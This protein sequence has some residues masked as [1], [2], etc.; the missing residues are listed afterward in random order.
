M[1]NRLLFIGLW[2]LLLSRAG[3]LSGAPLPGPP[4][5]YDIRDYGA[6]PSRTGNAQA[7]IQRAIEACAAAG[8][9]QVL[10]PAGVF[11]TATIYLRNNVELR[12]ASGATLLA[13]SDS[14]LYRNDKA[15]LL[16]AGDSFIPALIVAKNVSNVSLTGPG[17][18]LGEPR[19]TAFI[20]SPPDAYPG[21][22]ANALAAGVDMHALRVRD[23]KVSLVYISGCRNVA[24]RDI[25]IEN[26]PNWSCHLQWSQDV[27]IRGVH[28]SSSLERG[29]NSDGLDIDGCKRVLVADCI[30]RTGDDAICLKT[31][32]QGGRSET[33]EDISVTNC[34]LSSSSCALKIG[35]ETNSDFRRILFTNCTISDTNRGMGIIVRDGAVVSDVV[36]SNIVLACHRRPFFWWGNGEAFHLTVLKRNDGS[37]VGRIENVRI[38]GISG[39][40]EGT[41]TITGFAGVGEEAYTSIHNVTLAD[42]GLT[43][44]PESERDKRATDGLTIRNAEGLDLRN[45]R[46]S[47]QAQAPEAKWAHGLALHTVRDFQIAQFDS[48]P[49]SQSPQAAVLLADTQRGALAWPLLAPIGPF[50]CQVTG[51]QTKE[52]HVQTPD[53]KKMPQLVVEPAARKAVIITN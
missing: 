29:V 52:L 7:A 22:T 28:I 6:Q 25:H 12:L 51:S 15:G 2:S 3:G 4:A 19:F 48:P 43:M 53:A 31:T 13:L 23:P 49:F 14:T 16:D 26:S 41:S 50:Y 5:V 44:Q 36:F 35:T 17:T 10:V 24:L 34:V 21:W 42:I 20:V 11:G 45:I 38:Q 37:K 27:T 40:V 8:G 1:I 32:R 46:V 9:G 18:V 39:R 30:I 33:C 47:W